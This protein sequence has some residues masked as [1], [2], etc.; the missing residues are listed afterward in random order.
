MTQINLYKYGKA[1]TP[2]RRNPDDPIH[3]YRLVAD[4]DKMLTC[5]DGAWYYCVDIPVEDLDRWIEVEMHEL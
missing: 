1:V 4:D 2:K 5:G 3:G